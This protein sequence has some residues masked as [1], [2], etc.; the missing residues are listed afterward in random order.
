MP[1]TGDVLL[2]GKLGRA[3]GANGNYTSLTLLGEDG[4]GVQGT[5]VKMSQLDLSGHF[6]Y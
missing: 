4:F 2:L 5:L 1:N 3:V 6:F